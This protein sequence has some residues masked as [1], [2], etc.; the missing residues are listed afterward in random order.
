MAYD[1]GIGVNVSEVNSSNV[2]ISTQSAGQLRFGPAIS[3]NA[4]NKFLVT[5]GGQA[6]NDS[7]IAG[8]RSLL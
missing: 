7:F 2:V 6:G 3:I 1:S 4:Q 5:Y 8:R